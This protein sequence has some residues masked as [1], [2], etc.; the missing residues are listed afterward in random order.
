MSRARL[1][2]A[3]VVVLL[4]GAVSCAGILGFERLHE[5]GG[6]VLDASVDATDDAIAP[7]DSAPPDA[8]AC[9]LRGI[10]DPPADAGPGL[11]APSVVAGKTLDVGVVLDGGVSN[12]PGF[13]LDRTCSVDLGTSSCTTNVLES[14]FDRDAK[15][16]TPTGVDNAGFSLIEY[17]TT[18]SDLLAASTINAG[19]Q[20][21]LYGAVFRVSNWN[22]Q[23][24][25]DDVLLE[26]F[27]TLAVAVDGGAPTFTESDD[28]ILDA[29]FQ[30]APNVVAST[31]KSDV[32]YVSGGQLIGRFAAITVP[33]KIADDPKPFDVK[34]QDAIFSGTLATTNGKTTIANTTIAGRWKT[35]DFLD[36][37]RQI[38]IRDGNGLTNT[39]L[40]EPAGALIYGGVKGEV[41][42]ARDIRSDGQDNAKLACDS[43]SMALRMES[44]AINTLGDFDAG[45]AIAPRC[46]AKGD[47]PTGDD[48]PP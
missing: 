5:E 47:V 42:N 14:T 33:I 7:A 17:I 21:G 1:L 12:V 18:F 6:L 15:D 38:F 3:S 32:A 48:C 39:T 40:C 19:I 31:V 44:Y 2:T 24:D 10:P 36:Q 4:G 16:K 35:S 37:L 23:P 26:I 29:R 34:A 22:G 41:C 20:K 28:W 9:G 11:V 30:V 46:T 13:N 45:A 27:P 25:D 8:G 43:I